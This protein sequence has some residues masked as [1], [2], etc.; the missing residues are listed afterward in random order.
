MK[1]TT[2]VREETGNLIHLA[3]EANKT[4]IVKE[5]LTRIKDSED[6]TPI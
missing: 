1:E 6:L 3:V 2:R 5:L 4:G